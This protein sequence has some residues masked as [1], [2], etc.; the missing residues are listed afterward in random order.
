M[1]NMLTLG[2]NIQLLKPAKVET[3]LL[4][5][6]LQQVGR[7]R[8]PGLSTCSTSV[9]NEA[10]MNFPES[11]LCNV[12]VAALQGM[13]TI[14]SGKHPKRIY[15]PDLDPGHCASSSSCESK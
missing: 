11:I 10:W 3:I 7:H 9:C 13:S 15:L 2:C 14:V 8:I 1:T 12:R 6:F 5:I 4:Q